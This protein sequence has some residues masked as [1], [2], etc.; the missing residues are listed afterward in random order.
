[1]NYLKKFQIPVKSL[2]LHETFALIIEPRIVLYYLLMYLDIQT[3]DSFFIRQMVNLSKT[4]CG[5][6]I[7]KVWPL[8]LLLNATEFM[9]CSCQKLD[10]RPKF[11]LANSQWVPRMHVF[12]WQWECIF[13]VVSVLADG[14]FV[15]KDVRGFNLLNSLFNIGVKQ[16][17]VS[18]AGFKHEPFGFGFGF[19]LKRPQQWSWLCWPK[20]RGSSEES[21][22]RWVW[23]SDWPKK[24]KPM[25]H[26]LVWKSE[27]VSHS[28]ACSML[29]QLFSIRLSN[30][31]SHCN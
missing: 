17:S 6:I 20:R 14:S 24:L 3:F 26:V 25:S 9:V 18:P 28:D 30:I 2:I 8:Y 12:Q 10:H 27:L 21:K 4:H 7:F 1:M 19:A 22:L 31:A 15:F 13:L 11:R 5:K 23:T 16:E 29:I